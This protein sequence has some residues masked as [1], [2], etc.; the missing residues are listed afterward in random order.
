MG[1]NPLIVDGVVFV[2]GA[3]GIVALDGATGREI[4]SHPS[5]GTPTEHGINYWESKDRSD[6]RLIFAANSFL[7]EVNARTG[8]TVNTFGNDGR[9]DLREGLGR[10]P[11]TI[12]RI[13]SLHPGRVF[14][15]L[16]ILGSATGEQYGAPP[17]DLRAYDVLTGK[18]AWTFHTVP[19]PGEPG[20]ETWPPDAW[21]YIGGVN[22]WGEVT[23][24]DKR[25]IVYFPLG[26][27]TFDLFGFAGRRPGIVIA[28]IACIF[29]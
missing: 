20:Y 8:V 4:W 17:G 19:R 2:R 14:E 13:Q 5:E 21:K 25:G 3:G 26:S 29:D 27:P 15:N 1:F 9:V 16:V 18:L 6:R 24:D 11:K 28:R 23:L 10:D 12:N 22:T 7:Q